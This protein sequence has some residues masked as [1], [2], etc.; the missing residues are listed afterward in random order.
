MEFWDNVDSFGGW[1]EVLI[2]QTNGSTGA[3]G[4]SQVDTDF[5]EIG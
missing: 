4:I 5:M 2:K 3:C 1:A